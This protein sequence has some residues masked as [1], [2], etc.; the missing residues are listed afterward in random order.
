[1]SSEQW[2][3]NIARPIFFAGVLILIGLALLEWCIR[4]WI[5]RRQGLAMQASDG[6]PATGPD[7]GRMET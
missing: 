4:W 1:M 2:A 3:Q 5:A 7:Q 6:A